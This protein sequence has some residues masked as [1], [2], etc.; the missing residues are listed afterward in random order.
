M[1]PR[2][3]VAIVICVILAVIYGY[4]AWL[5]WGLAKWGVRG[6]PLGRRSARAAAAKV[7]DV[8]V[9]LAKRAAADRQPEHHGVQEIAVSRTIRGRRLG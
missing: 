4:A 2:G 9:A 8:R 7:R 5:F 1:R 3:T 6:Q